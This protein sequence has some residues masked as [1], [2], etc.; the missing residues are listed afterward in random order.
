M[1]EAHVNDLNG[2]GGGDCKN[3]QW[4]KTRKNEVAKKEHDE[5]KV[6]EQEKKENVEVAAAII[7]RWRL[8]RRQM[9][10]F[11]STS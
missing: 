2:D 1:Q 4:S 5:E 6:E 9:R 7:P 10:R 8:R 3:K 11:M